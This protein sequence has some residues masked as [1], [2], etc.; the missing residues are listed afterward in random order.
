MAAGVLLDTSFLITLADKN[1]AHHETAV[2]YWRHFLDNQIPIFLSTIVVSEF[3][4]KQEIPPDMLRCCVVL[5]FNWDDAQ[6]AGK[7]EW[8][9]LRPAGVERDAL[10]DDI[11]IIAQAAGVDAEF[12]ITDDAESFFRYCKTFKDASEVK[13]KAIKL[14]DGFDR[15]FFDPN[16]QREFTDELDGGSGG[17]S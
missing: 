2:Q 14:E 11:K 8:Q 17:Q 3:C 6:R 1:R 5:P 13:F 15:A 7:L 12:V 10:K 4:A 16:G 9:R